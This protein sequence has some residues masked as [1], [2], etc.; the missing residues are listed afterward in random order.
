[1][2]KIL[3]ISVSVL[4]TFSGLKAQV[5]TKY[6]LF[7]PVPKEQLRDMETDRPDITESPITT[8]AGH[9]QVEKKSVAGE[10]PDW[11]IIA[12]FGQ[13]YG[14]GDETNIDNRR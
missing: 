8:D 10:R 1:M 3:L 11:Q 7:H 2:K 13:K 9:I 5:K 12:T 6:N 4:F 14:A